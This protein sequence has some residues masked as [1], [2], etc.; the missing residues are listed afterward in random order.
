MKRDNILDSD[1][2]ADTGVK[3]NAFFILNDEKYS[4]RVYG[5]MTVKT[6]DGK[7]ESYDLR[8]NSLILIK[9]RI[10]Q[11]K[12]HTNDKKVFLWAMKMGGPR[13]SQF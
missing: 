8:N 10:I 4:D 12:V 7:E 11:Y 6:E 5:K 2:S 9:S 3:V 1:P 13:T